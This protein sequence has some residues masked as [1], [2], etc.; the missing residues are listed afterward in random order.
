MTSQKKLVYAAGGVVWR[1]TSSGPGEDGHD[2]AGLE[3]AIIHRPRYDDWTLPKGKLEPGETFVAAAVREIAEET[4]YTVTLG[5][6][7]AKVDYDLASSSGRKH[8]HYWSARCVAGEFAVNDEVDAVEWLSIPRARDRCSFRADRKVLSEFSRLPADLHTV[9]VVRHA[10]AG[11]SARYR[12]DDRLRPLE[13]V[14]RTQAQRLVDQFL[15]FGAENIYAADRTRCLQTVEPLARRLDAPIRIEPTL[16]EEAYRDDPDAALA[17][18]REI[19]ADRSVV[20]VIC[21]QGKVI[22]PLLA[23]WTD[24][25]DVSL[26]RTRNRKASM[27]AISM[28]GDAIVAVDHVDNPLR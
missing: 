5:R 11:R 7:L 23:A 10:K 6:R 21:S 3:V 25:H 4:G 17:R 13:P 1:H 28:S 27:W 20:P 18:L 19:A 2:G 14:G 26:P 8:V 16:S 9:L 15:M 22:P 12:G 24:G